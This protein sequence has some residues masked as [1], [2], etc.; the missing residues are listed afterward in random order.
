MS[1]EWWCGPMWKMSPLLHLCSIPPNTSDEN[2]WFRCYS[3]CVFPFISPSEFQI[4]AVLSYVT[5]HGQTNLGND[6]LKI[7]F[8]NASLHL[9]FSE[10]SVESMHCRWSREWLVCCVPQIGLNNRNSSETA[11]WR[12]APD[13]RQVKVLA[14]FVPMFRIYEYLCGLKIYLFIQQKFSIAYFLPVL[15]QLECCCCC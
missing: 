7:E 2:T 8:K 1:R 12:S 4:T 5:L 6:G 3:K 10:F 14:Y 11:I 13:K 9:D 15:V